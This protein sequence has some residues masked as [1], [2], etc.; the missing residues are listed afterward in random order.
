MDA[1]FWL[2]AVLAGLLALLAWW[3]VRRR[4]RLL[5]NVEVVIVPGVVATQLGNSRDVWVYLPPGYHR[6]PDAR[7]PVLYVNDG[8]DREIL[9]LHETLA[10]L[11]LSGRMEPIIAVTIPTDE[12]RLHEYGTT[13]AP[14][15][16]GLGALAPAYNHFIIDELMP[17][18]DTT[19]R[20]RP[21]AVFLGASLGGLSAFDI[22]WNNP[23]RFTAVGVMSGSFWWR[24]ADD[25]ARVEA[26][27]RIAHSLARSAAV[28]PT[29]RLW[30]QTGTRDEVNDRDGDGVIDAIQDTLELIEALYACGCRPEQITYIE[31][32]GGRH[33][34]ETWSRVLPVFLEWAFRRGQPRQTAAASSGSRPLR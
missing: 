32:E 28:A 21:E 30:L 12:R 16:Q 20:T 2:T 10:Q 26:G 22:V 24:A 33:D 9:G 18:I 11:Q 23:E 19:F 29:F 6:R 27:Q 34:Y 17:L 25:E 5:G 8:Q 31:I 15:A 1:V 3:G 7:Y 4:K 13:V 14:N